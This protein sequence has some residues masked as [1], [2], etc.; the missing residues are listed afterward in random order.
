MPGDAARLARAGVG[1]HR[2]LVL[3]RHGQTAWNA[4]GRF[5]GQ[6]DPPLDA[7]GWAQAERLATE[8]A[9]LGPGVLVSSDLLRARQTA[10]V[11]ARVCGLE[12]GFERALREVDLGG[13]EG[14]S[15]RQAAERFP[16]EYRRWHEGGDA[17]RGGGESEGEAGARA[18][19]AVRRILG[20]SAGGATVLVVAHGL[21]LKRAMGLLA[22]DGTIGLAG[23]PPHLGNGR[24]IAFEVAAAVAGR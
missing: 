5:Q 10:T 22:E 18:A 11:L 19:A 2:R 24:W 8:V 20:A 6:A 16:E 9:V 4:A 1:E 17:C 7:T 12:I 21:V 15:Q 13:W 23:A 14:L 3:A